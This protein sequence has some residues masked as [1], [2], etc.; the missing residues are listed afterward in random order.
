MDDNQIEKLGN[1]LNVAPE[2]E[3]KKAIQTNNGNQFS[4]E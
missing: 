4:L 1:Q 2:I 3:A